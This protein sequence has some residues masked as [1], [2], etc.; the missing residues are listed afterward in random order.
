[1]GSQLTVQIRDENTW[2]QTKNTNFLLL[3]KILSLH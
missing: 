3:F 2:S 1:M